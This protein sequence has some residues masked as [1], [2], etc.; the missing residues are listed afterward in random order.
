MSTYDKS[1]ELAKKYADEHGFTA[2]GKLIGYSR[3]TVS[4]FVRGLYPG[5]AAAVSKAVLKKLN[6]VVCPHLRRDIGLPE[7]QATSSSR[8]PMH[9][10]MKLQHWRTCQRC[11]KKS[12]VV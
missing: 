10:P 12:E 4:L 11:P 9:N 5:D 8:A 1:R 6:T 2:L 7:C 3:P